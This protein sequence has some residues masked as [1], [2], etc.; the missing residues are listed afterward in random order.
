MLLITVYHLDAQSTLLTWYHNNTTGQCNRD[1]TISAVKLHRLIHVHSNL[2][3]LHAELHVS[4]LT[5]KLHRLM[6]Y[7][8]H[9]SKLL[10]LYQ[11]FKHFRH[12]PTMLII[13]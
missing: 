10:S 2:Q 11:E 3:W 8:A 6:F 1:Q 4:L 9:I 12:A 5:T 13:E 7:E